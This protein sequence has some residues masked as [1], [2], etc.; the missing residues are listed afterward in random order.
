MTSRPMAEGGL[1]PWNAVQEQLGKVLSSDAFRGSE[2]ATRLLRYVVE[3]TAS[4]H[5]D[6][7]KEYTV[8][9][10]ALGKAASFDPRADPIVRAEASRLRQKLKTYYTTEGQADPLIITLPK[11]SYVPRI[12]HR[13]LPALH[14]ARDRHPLVG[15]RAILYFAGVVPGA[16]S[17]FLFIMW[18]VPRTAVPPSIAVVPFAN[19]S[20]DPAQEF[21]S[22][23][24]TD[25]I[26][27]ALAKVPSLRVVGRSSAYAFKNQAK[28]AHEVGEA[29]GATYL[30]EGS[31]RQAVGR[32]RIAVQLIEARNGLQLWSD[33]YDRDLT[34]VFAIQD[35]VARS[36]ATALVPLGD[37]RGRKL[38]PNRNIDPE[39]YQ[40]FLR[41]KALM[42]ARGVS[43]LADTIERLEA[44]VARDPDFAPAWGLL[45]YGHIMAPGFSAALATKGVDEFRRAGDEARLQTEKAALRA[46]QLDPELAD[47]YMALGLVHYTASRWGDAETLISKAHALD[48]NNPEVMNWYSELLAGIGRLKEA[49]DMNRKAQ[50]LE[51]FVPVFKRDAGVMLWLNGQNDA[52]IAM[53]GALPSDYDYR[54]VELSRVLASMARYQDAAA[55]LSSA[56]PSSRYLPAQVKEAAQMLQT[57]P[58]M[59]AS[60]QAAP[61]LGVLDFVYLHTGAPER[62]IEIFESY[63]QAG[64]LA[65]GFH[66]IWHASYAPLRKTDRFKTFLVRAGLVN[67]WRARGW[68]EFCQPV[69]TVD[70]ACH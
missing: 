10:E 27:A 7:L 48:P 11:G 38:V 68:P 51:P 24:M 44:V 54:A 58:T 69:S 66:Q 46:I 47:G 16:I 56:P 23:G 18:G 19:L 4:G 31:V 28:S 8:A 61:S 42:R 60:V 20:I 64:Y 5:T 52:A 50:E 29:L 62:A 21:F 37:I 2:R 12:E 14:I 35:E 36:I 53:L 6:R 63:A 25:E 1:P 70:F 65:I 3:Q 49:L 15:S 55:V 43:P 57:A 30:L 9:V 17:L 13:P 22:D 33:T 40:E 59:I 39:N 45:A 41:A 26:A 34:D 67:Y 32:V